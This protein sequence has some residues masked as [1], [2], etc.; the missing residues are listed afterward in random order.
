MHDSTE[1]LICHCCIHASNAST[2]HDFAMILCI[3]LL[4]NN[5]TTKIKHEIGLEMKKMEEKFE[6]EN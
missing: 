4:K 6:R 5:L 1:L 3:I 2:L